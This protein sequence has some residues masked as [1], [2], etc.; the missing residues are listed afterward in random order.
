MLYEDIYDKR[1]DSLN[2][3]LDN[4]SNVILLNKIKNDVTDAY[5]K[6]KI[7]EQ[8]YNLLNEKISGY[9]NKQESVNL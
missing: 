4:R 8:H 6:G 9:A 1:I 3:K 5:A 2:S 7:S